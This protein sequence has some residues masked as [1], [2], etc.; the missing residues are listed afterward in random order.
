MVCSFVDLKDAYNAVNLAVLHT[1]VTRLTLPTRAVSSII[2][3]FTNRKI[4]VRDG[5]NNLHGPQITSEGLPQG[6]VLSPILFNIYTIDLHEIL[7]A[8]VYCIEFADDMCI[9]VIHKKQ[10]DAMQLLRQA[11]YILK[12]WCRA[13]GFCI[14]EEKSAVMIFNRKRNYQE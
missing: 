2:Q 8:D 6:S 13:K 1:E 3:L 9:Y 14:S 10:C 5:Y 4:Y 7:G 12:N 11:C